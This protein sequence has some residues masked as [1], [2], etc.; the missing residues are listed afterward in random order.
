MPPAKNPIC[1][2]VSV[3]V[4]SSR[5]GSSADPVRLGAGIAAAALRSVLAGLLCGVVLA[6]IASRLMSALFFGV[7]TIDA[8][9]V[10]YVFVA[11]VAITLVSSSI[12]AWRAGRIDPAHE[13]RDA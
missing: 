11:L 13:L 8:T 3:I 2:R 12:P 7:G 10:A 5:S 4:P 6:A 1:R 9:T